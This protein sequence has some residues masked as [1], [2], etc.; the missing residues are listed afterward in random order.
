MV[1]MPPGCRSCRRGD[2]DLDRHPGVEV[3]VLGDD[4]AAIALAQRRADGLRKTEHWL[5]GPQW[6]EKERR[7]ADKSGRW[8]RQWPFVR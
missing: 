4:L 2:C 8:T 3:E 5:L 1:E 6:W 7:A